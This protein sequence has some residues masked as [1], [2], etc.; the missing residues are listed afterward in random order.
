MDEP[1]VE[2]ILAAAVREMPMYRGAR[3]G[4]PHKLRGPSYFTSHEAFAKT[5][6]PTAAFAV[7]LK[8]P[9]IASNDEWHSFASN[10]W[11]PVEEIASRLKAD[12]YDGVVNVRETPGGPLYT[13]LVVSSA[14]AKPIKRRR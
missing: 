7:T 11:I 1:T 5:Y 4:D 8:K 3:S 2:D 9:L 13:V 10:P 14:Q 6:G 12:G